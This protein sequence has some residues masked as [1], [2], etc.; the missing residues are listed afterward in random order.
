VFGQLHFTIDAIRKPACEHQSLIVDRF[1][2][3]Q[4]VIQTSEPHTHD[5]DHRQ[6][7]APREIGGILTAI[8]WNAKTSDT[9][10]DDRLGASA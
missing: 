7:K 4:R 3:Q 6:L 2:C 5:H 8:E 9:F 10:N 1:Q